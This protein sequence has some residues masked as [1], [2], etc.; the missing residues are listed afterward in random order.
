MPSDSR[1]DT[2]APWL[3]ALYQNLASCWLRAAC[4][5]SIVWLARRFPLDR[6]RSPR[7]GSLHLLSALGFDW[8]FM[9]DGANST[10]PPAQ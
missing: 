6:E 1:R 2:P 7:A 3:P 5:P 4:T 10:P 8:K 9:Q